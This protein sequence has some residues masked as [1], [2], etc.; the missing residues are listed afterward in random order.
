MEDYLKAVETPV[1]VKRQAVAHAQQKAAKRQKSAHESV[2]V[3]VDL[4]V[5]LEATPGTSRD[6]RLNKS[7][8]TESIPPPDFTTNVKNNIIRR[9]VKWNGNWVEVV[10]S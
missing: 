10:I 7:N 2:D 6:P 4:N 9:I 5:G 8:T 3:H 1:P